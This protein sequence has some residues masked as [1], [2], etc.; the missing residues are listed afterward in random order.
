MSN[1]WDKG[2]LEQN[3]LEAYLLARGRP[4]PGQLGEL[5]I[6]TT[7]VREL[8]K[9]GLNCHKVCKTIKLLEQVQS[10][11]MG[12]FKEMVSK[13]LKGVLRLKV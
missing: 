3:L 5:C 1:S 4:C 2:L 8:A 10:P 7:L 13:E 6:L 9:M 12:K 11:G